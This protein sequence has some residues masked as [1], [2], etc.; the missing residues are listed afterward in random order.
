MPKNDR[1]W[2]QRFQS[3][4]LEP[5]LITQMVRKMAENRTPEGKVDHNIGV[6]GEEGSV[7]DP[8]TF[9]GGDTS[10]KKA[11]AG[12][13]MADDDDD[14]G[15]V[16]LS[17]VDERGGAFNA[18]LHKGGQALDDAL[19]DAIAGA[20]AR[21]AGT[22]L[23]PRGHK[24]SR[25]KHVDQ[26]GKRVTT[27]ISD[28]YAGMATNT[29]P[30]PKRFDDKG[31]LFQVDKAVDKV[32]G[33]LQGGYNAL[34]TWFGNTRPARDIADAAA[35]KNVGAIFRSDFRDTKAAAGQLA[36][37][38]VSNVTNQAERDAYAAT[39]GGG[40]RR[41]LQAGAGERRA[42]S[43]AGY[44]EP[45]AGDKSYGHYVQR[46]NAMDQGKARTKG[47]FQHFQDSQTASPD[48][49]TNPPNAKYYTG[50]KVEQ[51][52]DATAASVKTQLV[53]DITK[54]DQTLGT[55][56]ESDVS[57]RLALRPFLPIMGTDALHEQE[58]EEADRMKVQNLMMGQYKPTNFPLGNISN[59]FWI[60][61]MAHEGIVQMDPLK[62]MPTLYQGLSITEGAPLY[63]WEQV[64]P[65]LAGL[66]SGVAAVAPIKSCGRARRRWRQGLAASTNTLMV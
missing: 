5:G 34:G 59:P 22:A 43:D 53:G 66:A 47:E 35:G 29:K 65:S 21:G 36:H 42:V 55:L 4:G 62:L 6:A 9:V 46:V 11:A 32:A 28:K 52:Q 25:P 48:P 7:E 57:Q 14:E 3:Y 51:T 15:E 20:D 37:D 16:D 18:A 8:K 64:L 58:T 33:V 27:E 45:K 60:S 12:A 19:D 26:V 40:N 23:G 54:R 63:G 2:L 31:V 13:A 50:S 1:Q 24:L 10:T 44:D 61:N 56:R 38:L 17:F 30:P 49:L 41:L 39:G